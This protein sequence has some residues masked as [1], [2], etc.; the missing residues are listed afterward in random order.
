MPLHFRRF[1]NGEEPVVVLHGLFGMSDNWK[2]MADRIGQKHCVYALDQR[3]HGLSFH[4]EAFNYDVLCADLHQFIEEKAIAPVK[5]IGHSLG[6]KVAMRYALEHE[7]NVSKLVVVDIAPKAY[8]HHP[9]FE[10]FIE[11]LSKLNLEKLQSRSDADDT[12]KQDIPHTAVRQFLLKNL[13][14]GD[15]NGFYWKINLPAVRANL[16]AVFKAITSDHTFNK[17]TLFVRGGRS[18]YI[19][20]EDTDS[21]R[22]LFPQAE[23]ATVEGATHWLHAEQPD[24]FCRELS[25]FL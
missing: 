25:R 15:D 10:H 24:A 11:V 13:A 23:I 4:S 17:P 19:K 1:C 21:I 9:L 18:D 2:S 7:E 12:L 5:L 14:R 16:T 6:G 8:E 20:D 22:N 3:N